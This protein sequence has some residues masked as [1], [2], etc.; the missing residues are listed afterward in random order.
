VF[1]EALPSNGFFQLVPET[2]V[3]EPLAGNGLFRLS[4]VMSQYYTPLI[5]KQYSN[6]TKKQHH[7]IVFS[8]AE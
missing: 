4:A 1:T 5:N 3:S 8:P 2:C 6:E 7:I